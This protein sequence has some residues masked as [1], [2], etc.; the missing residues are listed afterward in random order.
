MDETRIMHEFKWPWDR[1]VKEAK[2]PF[3][4]RTSDRIAFRN[5]RRAWNW[6]FAKGP[7]GPEGE[8]EG[9]GSGRGR[10]RESSEL[11]TPLWFGTGFHFALEDFH[12]DAYRRYGGGYEA[13]EAYA[14]ACQISGG[15]RGVPDNLREN[16]DQA[17]EM[18]DYYEAWLE[19]PG[20]PKFKTF[21]WNGRPAVEVPF[22]I[23][24]PYRQGDASIIGKHMISRRIDLIVYRGHIDR[25]AVDEYGQLW[26]MEYKTAAQY[27][28]YH[29]DIDPQ[30]TAYLW[31]A[32][33]LWP[34]EA[35]GGVM[36]Q[37][38]HKNPPKP[39]RIL[40]NGSLSTAATQNTSGPLYRR[41]LEAL[42]GT[43]DRAPPPQREFYG[44]L[45]TQESESQDKGVRWDAIGRST[46]QLA[47]EETKIRQELEDI[48]N[49]WIPMYPNPG[50][51]CRWCAFQ[52]ACI[53][54][55]SGYDYQEILE[56]TTKPR[57]V[58][59]V[60]SWKQHL[61]LPFISNDRRT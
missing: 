4:I 14:R 34:D 35:W 16:L 27:R 54:Y 36:Y 58:Y 40:K 57:E 22:E 43:V 33:I 56:Q 37:Q 46:K 23:P 52:Q 44:K 12:S 8:G 1:I 3:Y 20:R 60:D 21:I 30:V 5:C 18:L 17:K 49:P 29:L 10:G 38:H 9:E 2:N 39:P 24:L 50:D 19:Y 15:E 7:N 47:S 32:R 45:M 51:R 55:D 11:Q 28:L 41:T 59:G 31:A 26:I 53:S 6:S 13:F 25:I 61:P 48:L 42:Y